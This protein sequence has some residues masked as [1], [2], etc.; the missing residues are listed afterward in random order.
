MVKADNN[1]TLFT[2]ES[3]GR[4]RSVSEVNHARCRHGPGPGQWGVEPAERKYT[5]IHRIQSDKRGPAL[6]ARVR[7]QQYKYPPNNNIGEG[8]KRNREREA[9]RDLSATW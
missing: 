2:G 5:E 1:H 6:T 7:P 3:G 4:A 8:G 9:T